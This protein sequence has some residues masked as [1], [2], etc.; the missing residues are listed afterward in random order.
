MPSP[1]KKSARC[2]GGGI[3]RF[4]LFFQDVVNVTTQCFQ[5]CVFLHYLREFRNSLVMFLHFHGLLVRLPSFS[6]LPPP[7]SSSFLLYHSPL[8]AP[9]PSLPPILPFLPSP[10]LRFSPS[11][12]LPFSFS[13]SLPSLPSPFSPFHPFTL[14]SHFPLSHSPTRETCEPWVPRSLH[15]EGVRWRPVPARDSKNGCSLA[16]PKPTPKPK[17][18]NPKT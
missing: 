10:L 2:L 4:I 8:P 13:F 11:P 6:S 7:S 3:D 16:H 17:I 5:H 15:L 18:P 1:E 9:L 14:P 12:L